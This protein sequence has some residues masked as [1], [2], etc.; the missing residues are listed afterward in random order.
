MRTAINAITC[1]LTLGLGLALAPTDPADVTQAH[2]LTGAPHEGL[3]SNGISLDGSDPLGSGFGPGGLIPVGGKLGGVSLVDLTV[4]H[5]GFAATMEVDDDL[6]EV[7]PLCRQRWPRAH[8]AAGGPEG[9]TC[10]GGNTLRLGLLGIDKPD[11]LWDLYD[12]QC[13]DLS[14]TSQLANR[15]AG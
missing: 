2:A 10:V 5:S 6:V 13:G 15:Y 11:C 14:G 8:P 1:T 4:A 3:E 9:A 12:P 7:G